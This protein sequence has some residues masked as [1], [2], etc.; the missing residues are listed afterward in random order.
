LSAYG[1]SLADVVNECQ[2][3]CL[4]NFN[5]DNLEQIKSRTTYLEK[6]SYDSLVKQGFDKEHIVTEILLNLRYEGTDTAMMTV[7]PK[8]SWDFVTNFTEKYKREFGFLLPNRDIIVDDIRVRGIGQSIHQSQRLTVYNEMDESKRN[9]VV[10]ET[11]AVLIKPVYFENGRLDT[12]VY[13]LE[14]LVVGDEVKGPALIADKNST[15]V[16]EPHCSALMTSQH[17]VISVGGPT[18]SKVKYN[19]ELDYI[20]L[21]IFG[22]RFM[23]IAEQMGYTLQKTSISTNIKE[24]LDF[25]CAI[26]GPD[27]G[28]VAN[29]PHIPVHLGSMQEAVRWQ[30]EHLG[31]KIYEGDVLVTNHPAAGGSHL[32]D[33]TVITPVFEKGQIVFFVASRGHHAD[34]GG[35]AAG[36]M[37]PTSTELYQEGVAIKSYKL[38]EGGRFNEEGIKKI[39]L[40][41]PAQYE[42][43]SGTRCLKDNI[44]DLKA[45]VAAN[46][47]GII[48]VKELIVEYGICPS[49]LHCLL[50]LINL[51]CNIRTGGCSSI[52]DAHSKGKISARKSV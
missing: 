45:Q 19:T 9:L 42:G 15:I 49:K 2:E 52:H 21:S 51:Q 33:I 10:P 38:V 14:D 20:Q 26:F 29:A 35:I 11:K 48:L 46:Q 37:P 40:E 47:R 23:S 50:V 39:L 3:P 5:H 28:L 32:P 31:D 4:L 24:R 44:S 12:P 18:L 27:S 34:I 8:D 22:H 36:S 6:Q 25:S 16:V 30:V 41:D 13:K 43:C 7:K 1:L 17:V